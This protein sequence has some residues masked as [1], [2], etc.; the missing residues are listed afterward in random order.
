VVLASVAGTRLNGV[1]QIL[2]SERGHARLA[3]DPNATDS[4]SREVK[5][6]TIQ[7]VAQGSWPGGSAEKMGAA[8]KFRERLM[9]GTVD[10]IVI[11][12]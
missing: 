9:I 5:L 6:L 2:S 3:R 12:P 8:S 10:V 11:E 4:Q 1:Q 7:S